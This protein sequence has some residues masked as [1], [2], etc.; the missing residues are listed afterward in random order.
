MKLNLT[1]RAFRAINIWV[2]AIL[3][4][5]PA[6]SQTFLQGTVKYFNSGSKPAVG[7]EIRAFGAN[8]VK[9]NEAGMFILN[10]SSKKPGDPVKISVGVTDHDGKALE[11]VN[12][13]ELEQLNLPANPENFTVEVIVCRVGQRNDAAQEYYDILLKTADIAFNMRLSNI[14]EQ[15]KQKNIDASTVVSL[16]EEKDNLRAER[17]SV[18]AKLEEQALYIANINLDKASKLVK[19][20]V[21][22]LDSSH[23][24]ES[25]ILILDNEILYAAYQ[26]AKDKKQKATVE[27]MQVITGFELKIKLLEPFFQ[28]G[29]IM[30]CC[31]NIERICIMEKYAVETHNSCSL[32]TTLYPAKESNF[33]SSN[34]GLV[35]GD[36]IENFTLLNVN[37]QFVS[38]ND[39]KDVKGYIIVFMAN[40]CP[41][42][43]MYEDRIIQLHKN[44]SPKGFPV[45]A[46]NP[47]SELI[48]PED[49]YEEMQKRAKIGNYPF[50]YLKD[51]GQ[52][53]TKYFGSNRTPQV[54]I[55][56]SNFIIRYI[57]AIDDHPELPSMAKNRYAENAINA[58]LR[59]DKPE[60]DSTRAIGTVI[61]KK[62]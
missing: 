21:G 42:S 19:D 22:K 46:I 57:G 49:S 55:A 7:V 4:T 28:S 23:D 20:A 62:Q 17:D 47:N 8:L 48:V 27:I 41:Y 31:Q 52:I 30:K 59:G 11:L 45:I 16:Q 56:D 18:V 32:W 26:T 14:E 61:K 53:I 34:K 5:L 15:L 10:F 37:G 35:V 1:F 25:A 58:M 60:V 29:E 6:K 44:Y 12:V 24:I 39:Y 36:K 33:K 3:T 51:E 2:V 13:K 38:L 54:F 40:H 9:T 50:V 43:Q